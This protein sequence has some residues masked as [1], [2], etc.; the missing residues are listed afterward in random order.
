MHEFGHFFGLN[1]EYEGGGPTELEF[2]PRMREPWSQN[3]TFLASPALR[4]LKWAGFVAAN[5]P[6]PTPWSY[7]QSQSDPPLYGAY[8]G[9]YA[10]SEP[11]GASHIP[12]DHCM[13]ESGPK[14]CHICAHAISG[15][16]RHDLGLGSATRAAERASERSEQVPGGG[17]EQVPGGG[18]RRRTSAK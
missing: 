9:G 1:E 2:A 13:M 16:I 14:F 5:A 3:I 10:D 12:G 6:V 11:R 17:S 4:E 18:S 8:R 7:W 15:K